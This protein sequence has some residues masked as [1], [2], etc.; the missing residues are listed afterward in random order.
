MPLVTKGRKADYHESLLDGLR[1]YHNPNATH[2]LTKD[3]FR[4]N[5]VFQSYYSEEKQDWVYED[6]TG[7]LL[8]RR[9]LTALKTAKTGPANKK[10]DRATEE[11]S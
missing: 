1:V 11:E 4:D 6:R 7:L 8:F 10:S 3:I 2:K 5:D 9:V